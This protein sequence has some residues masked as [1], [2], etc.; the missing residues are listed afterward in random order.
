VTADALY[1]ARA[2]GSTPM[3]RAMRFGRKMLQECYGDTQIFYLITDGLPTDDWKRPA[4]E[5]GEENNTYLRMV[6][7]DP[8]RDSIRYAKEILDAAGQNSRVLP[9]KP[10]NL[11]VKMFEDLASILGGFERPEDLDEYL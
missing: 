9:V 10:N 2:R 7:I 4:E 1:T 8:K 3:G 11:D 6:L 5:L